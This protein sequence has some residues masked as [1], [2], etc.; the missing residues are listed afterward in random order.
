MIAIST[1]GKIA[2]FSALFL[3]LLLTPAVSHAIPAFSRQ[4]QTSC[5]TCHLDFPKLNDFGKAFKDAGFKFPTDN[6]TFLKIPPVLLGAPAQKEL[7]PHSIWPGTIPGIT[8][9]GIRMNTFFQA[10]GGNRGNFDAL[11]PAGSVPP[12]IPK[13]DFSTGL[14]SIF[15]AGNFGSDIA[16]WVDEDISIAG[17]NTAGGLGDGYLRFVNFGRFFKLPKDALHLR[18]G[19]FELDLPFTQARSINISPYDIYA[20]ANIGITS[21]GFGQH[22][23]NNGF[24]IADGA[25]GVEFSGGHLY[26]GYHYSIA[27]VDQNTSG[28]TQSAN[29]SSFV[30]SPTG[31]ANGGV[32]FAS[33]SNFKDLYGRFSYRFNLERDKASRTAVQAAGPSG[34]RD[35]T[36]LNLGTYYFYGRSVQ[37]ISGQDLVGAPV[38]LVTREPFYRA[39]GDFS[40]NYRS[41]NLFGLYMYGHDTNQL[42]IDI[43]GTLVPLPVDP[44]GPAPVGFVHGVPATFSGGF[45]QADLLALPWVMVIG[46]WDAVNSSADRINGLSLNTSTPFVLPAKST[47]NRATAGVQFLIHANIKASFE[48][49]FRPKQFVTVV[50]NPITGLPE[51]IEPFRTNTAVAALEWVF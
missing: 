50:T 22:F 5:A 4:Y 25:N 21:P 6:E 39:G 47:R 27:I 28:V 15:M 38:V 35:H 13:T 12:F 7:W 40:F 41:F 9:I 32:G 2:L 3:V 44:A 26:G 11:T 34:P 49:Q 30:P 19:R 37:R 48:Y 17:D 36:Y 23:V 43:T 24:T 10:T 18:V 16:F 14:F 29:N 1:R 42:P 46:R 8:P 45:V 33:D 51:A 31:G 20:Q